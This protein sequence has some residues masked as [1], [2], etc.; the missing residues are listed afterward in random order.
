MSLQTRAP[1]SIKAM[2][3][4][5]GIPLGGSVRAELAR[6]LDDALFGTWE[7]AVNELGAEDAAL[8]M[9][10]ICACDPT[11]AVPRWLELAFKRHRAA[12]F[13][14]VDAGHYKG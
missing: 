7:T 1:M 4:A 14:A 3:R 12:I 5:E 10:G 2:L 13:H 9:Y 11:F 6:L 8:M